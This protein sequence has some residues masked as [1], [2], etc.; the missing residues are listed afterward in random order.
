MKAVERDGLC[1]NGRGEPSAD[2]FALAAV[3][4]AKTAAE[5]RDCTLEQLGDR[6][7][8]ARCAGVALRAV[9]QAALAEMPAPPPAAIASI[10][11]FEGA[12]LAFCQSRRAILKR[13]A[14]GGPER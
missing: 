2:T 6:S 3:L 11:S 5:L 14:E 13:A 7:E 12:A 1:F 4:T 8:L 10:D 9:A